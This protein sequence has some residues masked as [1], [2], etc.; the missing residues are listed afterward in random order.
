M[1]IFLLLFK[2]IDEAHERSLY[3]D[4]LLG[5]LKKYMS[6]SI[7][8]FA[9]IKHYIRIRRKRPALRLIISSATLDARAFHEYFCANTS[10]D[11]AVIISLE[12]RT[13]PVEVAY[14]KKPAPDYVSKAVEIVH[15][16]NQQVCLPFIF[17]LLVTVKPQ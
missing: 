9:V 10:V 4:L 17:N 1:V 14:L 3:T 8:G 15:S 12:G 2:Q 6:S 13:Y 16:I 5:V 7:V 11:E